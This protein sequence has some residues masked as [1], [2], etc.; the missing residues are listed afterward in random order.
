MLVARGAHLIDADVIA[1]EVLE[2]GLPA[3]A[4]VVETFGTDVLS[5]D[6]R[7]DRAELARRVFSD[8][9]ARSELNAIVHP[10]VEREILERLSELSGGDEVVVLDLP[11]LAESG[12][13]HYPVSGVLVV[14]CPLDLALERL[15]TQRRMTREDAEARAAAQATRK[16]RARLADFII[17]NM[18][19]LAELSEMVSLAWEWVGTLRG[20][21]TAP[22]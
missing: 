20:G 6:G 21:P 17:M 11:L 18:G 5:R 9:S 2:P 1:R 15:V 4:R 10:E 7:L 3:F 16:E 14:D 13:G 8:P 22:D 19:T 12:R